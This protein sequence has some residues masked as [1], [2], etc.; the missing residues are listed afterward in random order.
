MTPTLR[1][2]PRS[3]GRPSIIVDVSRE[4]VERMTPPL[5]MPEIDAMRGARVPHQVFVAM[6]VAAWARAEHCPLNILPEGWLEP[7]CRYTPSDDLMLAVSQTMR[8]LVGALGFAIPIMV[9]QSKR[10]FAASWPLT[11]ERS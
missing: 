5:T 8:E 3:P 6:W 4:P 7:H 1:L 11:W 9:D 2:V 10:A